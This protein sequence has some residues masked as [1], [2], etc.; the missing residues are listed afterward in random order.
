MEADGTIVSLQREKARKAEVKAGIAYAG[1][2]QVGKDR[3]RTV[4][5]SIY[6]D[7]VDS[8]TFWA[9]MTVK[10]YEKYKVESIGDMV[11]GGDGASWIKDG[12]AYFGG[13]YPQ[14]R[15]SVRN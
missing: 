1:W 10:L 9:G 5:K 13:K 6:M 2:E 4:N 12:V 8:D 3:Y 14:A 11:I 7:V 15:L